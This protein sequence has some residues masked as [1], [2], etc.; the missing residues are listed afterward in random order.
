VARTAES[1][2]LAL[3]TRDIN[4]DTI[5][6]TEAKTLAELRP[7]TRRKSQWVD[8]IRD[9]VHQVDTGEADVGK[10]YKIGTWNAP[11][12]AATTLK[13]LADRAEELPARVFDFQCVPTKTN[14]RRGSELWGA[15]ME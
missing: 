14:G 10:Y 4:A 7:P 11:S 12:G 9:L 8:K 15:V 3:K 13:M 6:T 2:D 1:I 5:D